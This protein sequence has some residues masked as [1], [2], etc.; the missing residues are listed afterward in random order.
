MVRGDEVRR[1]VS[2]QGETD[3]HPIAFLHQVS[4]FV[5]HLPRL[6]VLNVQQAAP[7]H[8]CTWK[9]AMSKASPDVM[10]DKK[11]TLPDST[12]Q[13][14]QQQLDSQLI[15]PRNAPGDNSP[16]GQKTGRKDHTKPQKRGRADNS[17]LHD[18]D[19]KQDS[20]MSEE[21]ASSSIPPLKKRREGNRRVTFARQDAVAC[22]EHTEGAQDNRPGKQRDETLNHKCNEY[23]E[24]RERLLRQAAYQRGGPSVQSKQL[25]PRQAMK[26]KRFE[27]L[28]ALK[29]EELLEQREKKQE[30]RTETQKQ[31]AERKRLAVEWGLVRGQI[32]VLEVRSYELERMEIEAKEQAKEGVEDIKECDHMIAVLK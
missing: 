31:L 26:T 30:A 19:G 18:V 24:A 2:A 9:W 17:S 27:K 23:S 28:L 12:P 7:T 6:G 13:T 29:E 22:E 16:A 4:A 32:D 5:G 1:L 10:T 11:N 20:V 8:Q 3:F 14:T 15:P 25:V 21:G